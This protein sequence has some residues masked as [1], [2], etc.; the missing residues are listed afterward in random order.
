MTKAERCERGKKNRHLSLSS[1]E[2]YIWCTGQ[3]QYS[4]P[5]VKAAKSASPPMTSPQ[6]QPPQQEEKY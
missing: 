4:A 5:G 1:N 3:N 2:L 6:K